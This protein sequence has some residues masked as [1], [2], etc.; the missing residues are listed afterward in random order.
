[1]TLEAQSVL[2]LEQTIAYFQVMGNLE[3]S[4]VEINAMLIKRVVMNSKLL[5]LEGLDATLQWSRRRTK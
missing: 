3:P 4:D 5:A 1:M 2:A